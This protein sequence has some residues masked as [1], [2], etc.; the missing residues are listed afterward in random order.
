MT[1]SENLVIIVDKFYNKLDE[2]VNRLHSE[3]SSVEKTLTGHIGE[4]KESLDNHQVICRKRFGDLEGWQVAAQKTFE[5]IGDRHRVENNRVVAEETARI[6]WFKWVIR[7]AVIM[8]VPAIPWGIYKLY[9]MMALIDML[10]K[11]I[12]Q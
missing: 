1:E 6:D 9:T 2:G 11:R 12:V 4:V 8:L 5:N 10:S 7:T 3:M